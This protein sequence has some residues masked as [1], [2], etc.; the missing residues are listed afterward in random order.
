VKMFALKI[1]L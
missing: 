1:M